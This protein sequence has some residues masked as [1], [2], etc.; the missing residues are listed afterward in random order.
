[1]PK[2]RGHLAS[3]ARYAHSSWRSARGRPVFGLLFL[4]SCTLSLYSLRRDGAAV[5]LAAMGVLVYP[6]L[7]LNMSRYW[8]L[9]PRPF[10]W[11]RL[12]G[13]VS[14]IRSILGDAPYDSA[15]YV[16]PFDGIF[17]LESHI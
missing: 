15:N 7:E 4:V 1:M 11:L 2:Q 9:F 16:A 12:A 3:A 17:I 5:Q 13:S 6:S 10:H 8:R 14:P